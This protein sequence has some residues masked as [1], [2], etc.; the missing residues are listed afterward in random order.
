[1][2]INIRF[3]TGKSFKID[4]NDSSTVFDLKCHVSSLLSI[5]LDNLIFIYDSNIL[6]NS[7]K[8]KDLKLSN[9][10]F[11]IA[12]NSTNLEHQKLSSSSHQLN[13]NSSNNQVEKD[14]FGR[15]VPFNINKLIDFIVN[16]SYSKKHAK[17]ALEF[18]MYDLHKAILLLNSG[19]VGSYDGNEMSVN[20]DSEIYY[21][22][23]SFIRNYDDNDDLRVPIRRTEEEKK[24]AE[25]MKEFTEEEKR[26]IERL[27]DGR[28]RSTVI[29][30]FLACDKDETVTENCLETMG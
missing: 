17:A 13:S 18:T 20:D 3:I 22:K 2:S 26:T 27:S 12:A 7:T 15:I 11:L 23:G 29:Q 10:S 16:L 14:R 28:D 1:M 5:N 19:K 24:L 9:D 21:T 25:K 30:V 6:E 8:L 4:I